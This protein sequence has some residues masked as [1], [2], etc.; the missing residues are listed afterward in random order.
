V[1]YRIFDI[2]GRLL[3]VGQSSKQA[4]ELDSQIIISNLTK[5]SYFLQAII[6]TDRITSKFIKR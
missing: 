3:Y 4:S 2:T 5:G 6:G 1:A